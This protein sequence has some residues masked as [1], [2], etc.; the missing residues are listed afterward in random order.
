MARLRAGCRLA[1]LHRAE[2]IDLL[3]FDDLRGGFPAEMGG[4]V[5][6]DVHVLR[7]HH[8]FE[9]PGQI[10]IDVAVRPAGSDHFA[11]GG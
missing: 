8:A 5:N 7:E 9:W 4:R 6:N 11:A 10:E 1:Q 3:G 2:H